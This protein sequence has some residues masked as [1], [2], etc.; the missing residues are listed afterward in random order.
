MGLWCVLEQEEWG[1]GGWGFSAFFRRLFAK[2]GSGEMEGRGLAVCMKIEAA[3]KMHSTMALGGGAPGGGFG[4][5]TLLVFFFSKLKY[6]EYL[7]D[8]KRG[9]SGF[10]FLSPTPM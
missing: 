3:R 4:I 9:R 8:L 5:Y 7:G 10:F 2:H 6:P 1:S